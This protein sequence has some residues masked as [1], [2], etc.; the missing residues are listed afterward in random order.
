MKKTKRRRRTV[1]LSAAQMQQLRKDRALIAKEL[2]RLAAKR[3][4]LRE[5]AAE[6]TTSGVLRRAIHSSKFLLHD[7]AQRA[8]TDMETL[9]DFLT[10]ERPLTSDVIDRL[11]KILKLRLETADGKIIARTAKP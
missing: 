2:P 3:E 5:A 8:G 4:R 10:G 7:L 6:R 1:Q 11:M 9:D